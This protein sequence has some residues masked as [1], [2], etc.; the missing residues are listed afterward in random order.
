MGTAC[1][2]CTDVHAKHHIPEIKFKT[3]EKA[4]WEVKR[5]DIKAVIN[6]CQISKTP[7]MC[8]RVN[9][10]INTHRAQQPTDRVGNDTTAPTNPFF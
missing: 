7:Y 6:M 10:Y 4:L 3:K 8:K 2:L 1:M 9:F 5:E